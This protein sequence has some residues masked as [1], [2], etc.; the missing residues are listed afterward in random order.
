MFVMGTTIDHLLAGKALTSAQEIV[1]ALTSASVTAAEM[2][3]ARNELL[4]VANKE[5]GNPD[6]LAEAWLDMD[7]YGV[8]SATESLNKV[9]SITPADL[10]RTAGRIFS[11]GAFASVVV[12][13]SDL[14]K[15]QL[16]TFGKVELM[17]AIGP[18]PDDQNQNKPKTST[19]S[20]PE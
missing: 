14:V 6:G 4:A 8:P 16:E 15:S 10:Q 12:G 13:N 17:G 3:Q 7:T 5:L 20:K 11:E 19:G 1:R 2:E 18:K 9:N